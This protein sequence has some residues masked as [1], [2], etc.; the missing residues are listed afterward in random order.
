MK[1]SDIF[2]NDES[3]VDISIYN[4]RI[5]FKGGDKCRIYRFDKKI[6]V[7]LSLYCDYYDEPE[8]NNHLTSNMVNSDVIN[9]YMIGTYVY[10]EVEAKNVDTGTYEKIDLKGGNLLE[11]SSKRKSKVELTL[12]AEHINDDSKYQIRIHYRFISI[13]EERKGFLLRNVIKSAKSSLENVAELTGTLLFSNEFDNS[14]SENQQ[15]SSLDEFELGD[16]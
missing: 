8:L 12:S 10:V 7:P 5:S 6:G 14:C 3:V 11:I 16:F 9:N 1:F 15:A 4:Q 13:L 2:V